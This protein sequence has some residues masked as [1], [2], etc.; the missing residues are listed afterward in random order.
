MHGGD[1]RWTHGA[2]TGAGRLP[3][4]FLLCV[5]V[6][7]VFGQAMRWDA[8]VRAIRQLAPNCSVQGVQSRVDRPMSCLG[9]VAAFQCELCHLSE[10]R[11]L[12]KHLA[13]MV[14]C[15]TMQSVSLG[16]GTQGGSPR[17]PATAAACP[18]QPTAPT[19]LKQR[20]SCRPQLTC[21]QLSAYL[22]EPK[23][24][25]LPCRLMSAQAAFSCMLQRHSIVGTLAGHN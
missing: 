2:D 19:V 14:L 17:L 6:N 5:G 12:Q 9:M 25:V 20:A 3:G 13:C 8:Q 22:P 15:C 24:C 10:P 11:G 1:S 23:E 16:A 7:A 18:R 21:T 4:P